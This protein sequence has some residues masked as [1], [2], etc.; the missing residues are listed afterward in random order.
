MSGYGVTPAQ[1][2][3][4]SYP[5]CVHR[6]SVVGNS[7]SGKTTVARQLAARLSVAHIELD[8]IFHQPD[9]QELPEAEFRDRVAR[10]AQD[11]A[12]VIDGNYS[13]VRDLIWSRAD[14][15]VWLDLPRRRVMWQVVRRTLGRSMLRRELWNGNREPLSNLWRLDPQRSIIAWA[16]TQHEVYRQRYGAAMTDPSN[17]HLRFVHVTDGADLVALLAEASASAGS[18]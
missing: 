12:W 16:W 5:A 10:V 7:G 6:V 4:A 9:W 2:D 14:T 1:A 13:A 3:R 8:A 11:S 18:R 15:V 17:A